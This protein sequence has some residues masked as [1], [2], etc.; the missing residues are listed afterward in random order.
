MTNPYGGPPS[1]PQPQQPYGQQPYPQSGP[2]PQQQYPQSGPMPQPG[3]PAPYG[4]APYG[5]PGGYGQPNPENYAHWGQRA[6]GYLID[7][8]IPGVI[9]G[10]IS[11]VLTS[12]GVGA[13]MSGDQGTAMTMQIINM[14]VSLALAA[15]VIWNV[16]Y[17]RGTTG[18]SLGQQVAKI[19][20][21]SEQ[22]GRP[23]GF[24]YAFLRQLAHFLDGIACYIGYLW[25]LWDEKRQT[26]ADKIIGS[27]VIPAPG[28]GG[29]GQPG[30]PQAGYPQPG[31]PQQPGGYPQQGGHPQQG[32]YPQSGGYPQQ[33]GYPP[34]TGGH[35]QQGYGQPPQQW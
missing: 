14:V 11:V 19:T 31:Y 23:L 2:Q 7:G 29:P 32:G 16:C 4:Q 15:F 34:Q 6:L 13:A 21:L 25:P 24:G 1:G 10:V 27:V 8:I 18:Q 20:T 5:A 9:V 17:R 30:Y 3:A 22:T 28:T 33:G 26:F 12:V 35:P